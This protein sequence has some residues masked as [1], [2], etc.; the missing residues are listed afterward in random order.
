MLGWACRR[1]FLGGAPLRS[2]SP[3]RCPRRLRACWRPARSAR[4]P[5]PCA[6]AR[7][8]ASPSTTPCA[9]RPCRPRARAVGL[10]P[11]PALAA[12]LSLPSGYFF[13]FL[14]L[15]LSLS[16]SAALLSPLGAEGE[17]GFGRR[18]AVVG[19]L[20]GTRNASEEGREGGARNVG[21]RRCPAVRSRLGPRGE[22]EVSSVVTE[23]RPASGS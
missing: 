3:A 12:P 13:L 18:S 7:T 4:D 16:L 10:L 22:S 23:A 2:W 11:V 5:T 20:A 6:T 15:P 14:L 1:R 9:W 17:G 21:K 8:T 19:W